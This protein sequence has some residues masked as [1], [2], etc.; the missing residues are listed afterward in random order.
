MRASARQ[1][2]GANAYQGETLN[3]ETPGAF[4]SR[5]TSRRWAVLN[6]LLGAGEVPVRELARR[7]GRDVKRVHEDAAELVELGLI[8]RTEHGALLC[9]FDDIHMDMHMR[10]AA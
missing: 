2:F 4:F 10:Q 5:L 1:A 8:E 6:T 3:F 9:P 7:L